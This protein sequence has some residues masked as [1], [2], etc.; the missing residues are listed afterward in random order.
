MHEE[1]TIAQIL[2]F[3]VL[4]FTAFVSG[5]ISQ[6]VGLSETAGQIIGGILVGPSF[7]K[8]I[9]YLIFFSVRFV[10]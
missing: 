10:Y 9:D 8:F 6:R 4:V 5:K 2:L 7:L 1:L 3:G